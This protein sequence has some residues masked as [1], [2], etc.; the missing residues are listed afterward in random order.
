MGITMVLTDRNFNT[1]FFETAGGGDPILFQ[2]LFWFFGLMWPLNFNLLKQTISEEFVLYLLGTISLFTTVYFF[3]VRYISNVAASLSPITD[4]K[5]GSSSYLN[6]WFIT[7]FCDAESSF[8]VSIYK[9]STCRK[10][11]WQVQPTFAIHI[12]NKDEVLLKRIQSYFKGIGKWVDHSHNS[13]VYSVNSLNDIINIIIPHFDKYPLL[14]QKF[15]DYQLFKSAVLL[16]KEK[17]HLT[18]EGLQEIINI[19]A[20]MNKG[21]PEDSPLVAEFKISPVNR[22][23]VSLPDVINPNWIAGFVDGE[24]C[25]FCRDN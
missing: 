23:I 20:S 14:T 22:C 15:A 21:L 24:G 5:E 3:K 10:T 18:L 12:H 9:K 8:V 25:F 19:R 1:S 16:M 4:S 11:G 6:P 7:G 2:H 17:K 13:V